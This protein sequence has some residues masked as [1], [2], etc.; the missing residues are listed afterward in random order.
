MPRL[1]E[2]ELRLNAI[3]TELQQEGADIEA[4]NL[5]VDNLIAERTRI[6]DGIQQRNNILAKIGG[7]EVGEVIESALGVTPQDPEE[8]TIEEIISTKEYA[9]AW[10]KRMMQ[11]P[12][13]DFTA[14]E[15][16]ALGAALTTTA[17]TAVAATANADGVNNGGLFIP[18]QF[19]DAF[20]KELALTSPIFSDLNVVHISGT[21]KMPY[22]KRQTPAKVRK[23]G[24]ANTDTE[25]EWGEIAI[26]LGEISAT[27]RVSW[28]L[29]AMTPDSFI[30]Y[31]ANELVADHGDQIIHQVIYGSG[32]NDETLGIKNSDV[33]KGDYAADT[34]GITVLKNGL[35]KMNARSKIGAVIYLSSTLSENIAF[36]QD[37][38]G[39]YIHNP[40]NGTDIHSLARYTV[41][42][43]P[44]L[45]D[46]DFVIGNLKRNT[47]FQIAEDVTIAKDSSGKNRVNDY[48][49]FSLNGLGV[50]PGTILFGSATAA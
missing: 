19:M 27:A 32:K 46:G 25:F 39:S 3:R 12:E 15:K 36:A 48:T 30:T 34:D 42:V 7:G 10:A 21:I 49:T 26:T 1:T 17:T 29:E 9:H 23:E 45:N 44:Y 43:D 28:R 31:L 40:V 41:K 16:R 33:I 38:N 2:I 37:K 4:L 8:R 50:K 20:T 11:R 6:K 5:E 18:T 14:A 13:S 47:L 35:A 24:V 22:K